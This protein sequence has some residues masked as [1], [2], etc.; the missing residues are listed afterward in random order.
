[1]RLG[2]I[3]VALGLAGLLV[4]WGAHGARSIDGESTVRASDLRRHV[5]F[6]AAD[7]LNGRD[8]GEPEIAVA[9]E[10][11]ALEF[12]KYG[13]EPLPG[14]DGFLVNFALFRSSFDI[15]RTRLRLDLGDRTLKAEAGVDF[16]P[17][18]FSDVGELES[19]IVFAG[20]GISAPEFDHD[21]YEGLDVTGKVVLLL[22]HEPGEQ[23][24]GSRFDGLRNTDHALFSTKAQTARD[25]GALGML[26]V[27]DPLHHTRGDD[28]RLS[29]RLR[30][31]RSDV[32]DGGPAADGEED[33]ERFLGL[34]IGRELAEA[35]VAGGGM[36][37]EALQIALD[38]G[39]R[40]S[41]LPPVEKIRVRVS[42]ERSAE[43]E[44]V[45]ARNVVGYL[46]GSDPE[47]R[48][49]WI[50]IGGHHD[51]IG[52]Y[53]GDGDTIYNGADD[54][55]SGTSGVLELAQAFAG[56]EQRPRRSLV[57]ATFSAEERGLLGSRAL[58]EQGA[59]PMD[60]V[61]FMLNLDMIGRNPRRAVDAVG[62]GYV[63]G[64]R[65]IV[66][67]SNRKVELDLEFGGTSYTG[68]SDHDPF[69]E[70]DVPFLFFFT[71][72]HDDY[73]PRG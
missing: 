14:Q 73:H 15:E 18:P 67:A 58:V 63:R 1:M 11:V 71:G 27:T 6:L 19:G 57:F 24:P 56:A 23:D 20:Y 41:A 21:D 70:R 43:V 32:E 38:G 30:L 62:D 60:R 45:S 69:Y 33:E 44:R 12:R 13:L 61:V 48:D 16:R 68:N 2:R 3:G 5:E 28:F 39:A 55:A 66:E 46:P 36:S 8:T 64:L 4:T 59:I 35:I 53:S 50:V 37:L 40:P 51:H 22:R 7:G 10:Y 29:G 72:T 47:R 31:D 42:V 9:E 65:E 52:G 25:H 49:E 54:N 26:L 34:H 17:F